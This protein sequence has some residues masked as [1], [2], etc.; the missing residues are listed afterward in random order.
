MTREQWIKELE[1]NIVKLQQLEGDGDPKTCEIAREMKDNL[2][3]LLICMKLDAVLQS[4]AKS[5][6][7]TQRSLQEL[8]TVVEQ[9]EG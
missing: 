5:L 7:E 1:K 2:L 9:F 4:I 8:Q 3:R 6:H